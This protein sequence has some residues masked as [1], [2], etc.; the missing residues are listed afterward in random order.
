MKVLRLS[1]IP[2]LITFCLTLL[3]FP[4]LLRALGAETYGTVLFIGAA[5]GLFGVLVDFGVSS[6][7]SKAMAAVR[8][9]QPG[10]IRHEFFVWARLQASFV[11]VGFIPM[12][13]AYLMVKGSPAL[14]D[15]TL[16]LVMSAAVAFVWF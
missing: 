3:S 16:L 6:A 14:Q 12:L 7:A 15:T 11:L 9:H 13:L 4:L 8:V 2:N 10:A 1:G 5:L